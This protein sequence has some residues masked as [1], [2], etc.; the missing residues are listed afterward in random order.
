[1][2]PGKHALIAGVFGAL[3]AT[4]TACATQPQPDG[5]AFV[6]KQAR[7][8]AQSATE[9]IH[10]A[11]EADMIPA[12]SVAVMRGDEVIWSQAFGTA[13]LETG[14]A[15]MRDTKF[16]IGSVS[17]VLT[18]D[19]AAIL[20]GEGAVDLDE[21][22]R[23]YLPQFP[24]KGAP[25][26]LRQ[27]LGHLG[28]IRHYRGKDFDFAQPGG[29]IDVR[30]YPDAASILAIF[31]DD[32][33]IAPPGEQYSYTT[34]GF[35]L[36]GLV[37]EAA[38]GKSYSALVEEKILAPAGIENIAVDNHFALVEGRVGYYDP[39]GR[40]DDFLSPEEY[41]PIVN[42]IPLNSAYKT[43]GGGHTAD[44]EAMAAFGAL[45]YAPGFLSE[46]VY[47][48]LFRTQKTNA[49]EDIGV[50]LAWRVGADDAGRRL[51]QHSGSQQGGRAHLAV[52][53]DERL[54]IAILSN[55]GGRPRAVGDLSQEIAEAFLESAEE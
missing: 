44:A 14:A 11:M 18:A 37:L 16:R 54:S 38:T 28:G 40:Y 45:H 35:S 42:A 7:A 49:G 22:I 10:A 46:N 2:F 48:E 33:L 4:L 51:L 20:A 41:G 53:P 9:A 43:P 19:L 24:D 39:V 31:A 6:V 50:G 3:A 8:S 21:D 5:Q 17:K 47:E 26:T 25:I 30:L 29:P 52:Y 55:L 15:A 23:T 1:M 12:M 27:L 36:I 13:N 34:F 32:P